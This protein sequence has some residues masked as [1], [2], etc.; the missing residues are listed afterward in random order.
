MN[1]KFILVAFILLLTT[2]FL[3]FLTGFTYRFFD[4]VKIIVEYYEKRIDQINNSYQSQIK[5]LADR[6]STLTHTES[7]FAKYQT[8][9]KDSTPQTQKAQDANW[10]GPKFWE[11]ISTK[12]RE[13]G[14]SPIPVNDLLCTLAAIRLS[15]IR[16]LGRLDD[17]QGFNPLVEKY[18]D[19]L[20]RDDLQSLFEFLTSGAPTAK[21]AVDG[22]YDTLGHKSLFT[23]IYKAGCAYASESFGVVITSK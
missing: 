5:E 18:K 1:F 19:D 7:S 14:L 12:R 23:E 4:P 9:T 15:E 3:S 17:H 8:S 6:I 2:A 21:E 13:V 20:N 11:E 16:R 22:L 10:S